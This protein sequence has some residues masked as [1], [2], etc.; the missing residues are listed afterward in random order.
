MDNLIC[1]LLGVLTG[2]YIGYLL[3]RITYD[4]TSYIPNTVR[5]N[6]DVDAIIKE[7]ERRKI[8]STAKEVFDDRE[9]APR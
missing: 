8:R 9:G 2:A 4:P 6:I 5:I 7:M 3:W 1:Y